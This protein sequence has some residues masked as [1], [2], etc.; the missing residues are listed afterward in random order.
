MH[1]IHTALVTPFNA[2]GGLDEAAFEALCA[3]QIEGGI[4]G[5]VPCGTTGETPTLTLAEQDRL[6]RLAIASSAGR[7]PVTAGIGSNN[8]REAVKNAERVAA[9]GAD[10]GL[11]VFPYYNKPNPAGLFAHVKAVARV[12]LPL[13]LYHVP[14][15]TG[16]RLNGSLLAELCALDGVIAIKEA[17]GDLTTGTQVICGT[18]RPVLSG[19]DFSFLGLLAQGGAGCVSVVSNVDP[20]RTVAVYEAF[21]K[22]NMPEAQGH[23]KALWPLIEFLFSDTNPVPAKAAMAMM[24]LCRADVRLPLAAFEGS[25]ERMR[26]IL[27]RLELL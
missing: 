5:L 20:S 25:E 21:R 4:H 23:L 15:R 13:V 8:T 24:G 26:G 18:D 10:A 22:G 16:Q 14:G 6:I 2:D 19:D 27:S 11:L 3:R 1:G 12:G 17:T 7:V 9:L